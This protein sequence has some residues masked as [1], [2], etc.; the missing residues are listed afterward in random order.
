MKATRCPCGMALVGCRC[1]RCDAPALLKPHW[2]LANAQLRAAKRTAEATGFANI[3]RKPLAEVIAQ[4]DPD[5][6]KASRRAG[7]RGRK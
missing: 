7:R 5:F 2:R 1:P 3:P 6:A 4:F